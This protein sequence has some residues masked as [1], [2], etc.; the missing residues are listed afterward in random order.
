MVQRRFKSPR[1]GSGGTASTAEKISEFTIRRLSTY[2]RILL[3]LEQKTITTVSSA[4][5]AD[6]CPAGAVEV[7]NRLPGHV[8]CECGKV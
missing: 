7:C 6:L 3:D 5:L 1:A 4:K 2:Y 8:A